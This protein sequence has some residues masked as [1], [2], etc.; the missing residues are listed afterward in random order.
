MLDPVLPCDLC[1]DVD[2]NLA[3]DPAMAGKGPVLLAGVLRTIDGALQFLCGTAIGS[4]V[5]L[6][7]SRADKIS[8]HV[9]IRAASGAAFSCVTAMKRFVMWAKENKPDDV[10]AE[11][12]A[13]RCRRHAALPLW[14]RR[15]A[16]ARCL[17][18]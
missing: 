3:T 13:D 8:Y 7:G 14:A 2:L 4:L 15:S 16:W 6:D 18:V 5:V 17:S 10:P 11:T 12:D 1:I 9:H